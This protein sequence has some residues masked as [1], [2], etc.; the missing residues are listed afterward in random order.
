M[1]SPPDRVVQVQG[2]A[3]DTVLCSCARHSALTVPLLC[4]GVQMG[5]SEL[6]VGGNL[7]IDYPIR[8]REDTLEVASSC[9]DKLQSDGLLNLYADFNLYLLLIGQGSRMVASVTIQET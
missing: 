6:N 5:T 3:E 1:H 8:G 7:V 2:L 9:W 4:P